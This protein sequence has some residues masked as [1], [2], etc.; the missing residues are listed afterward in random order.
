MF[1]PSCPCVTTEAPL[2]GG[3]HLSQQWALIWDTPGVATCAKQGGAVAQSRM[4]TSSLNASGA[5]DISSSTSSPSWQSGQ[6]WGA[7][8]IQLHFSLEP[9]IWI[10][11]T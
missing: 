10:L 2:G 6:H 9:E 3:V 4:G 5:G 1:Q 8:L 11:R 7:L